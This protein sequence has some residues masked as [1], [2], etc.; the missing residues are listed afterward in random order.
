VL[1]KN[2]AKVAGESITIVVPITLIKKAENNTFNC[3]FLSELAKLL[4]VK[5]LTRKI[6]IIKTT[7]APNSLNRGIEKEINPTTK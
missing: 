1:P 6:N 7:T 2:R 5:I 3:V 4:F